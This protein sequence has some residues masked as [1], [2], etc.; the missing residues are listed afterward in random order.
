ME[1][2]IPAISSVAWASFM[3]GVNPGKHGIFGFTDRRPGTY[4]LYFPNYTN[5]KTETIWDRIGRENG[6]CCVLN[7]PSTY[8]AR[9]L[10]GT[11][12]SGF[13]APNLERAV[14]P[15]SVFD[16]LKSSGYRIDVDASKARQS[17]EALLMDLH[18]T[19]EKRREAM[20]H[21]YRQE[22]WE[23][24]MCVFTGT[25]RL[26][27]FLWRHY[28]RND[29]VYKEEFLRYYRRLDEIIG[30]F[31]S[32]VPEDTALFLL[33]DHGFCGIKKEIFIN[34]M[35]QQAGLLKF[36]KDD[37]KTIADIDPQATKAY[38]LDPGRIYLN[39]KG[40][41]PEGTVDPA[42]SP[43]VLSDITKMLVELEDPHTG[44]RV[45]DRV[46]TGAELY[47]GPRVE[48]GPDLVAVP[49]RGFD[50]KGRMAGEIFAEPGLLS[51]MHTH[52]DAFVFVGPGVDG[53]P[54]GHIRELAPLIEKAGGAIS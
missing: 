26:H 37:P 8:P 17:L 50:L 28:E 36:T 42:A 10:N 19:L 9:P 22:A 45:I 31:I 52:D 5:L 40:R 23:F 30:E 51:G 14:Y 21:F 38:C 13:V 43:V 35:L 49:K 46:E 25:D 29:P 48:K 7:V 27:H 24:F 6:R 47:S 20:L 18:S 32:L 34:R 53:P 1:T 44:V 41:E 11:L 12:V 4:E 15:A 2:E 39:L 3:T 54:P 16:Y 33:S